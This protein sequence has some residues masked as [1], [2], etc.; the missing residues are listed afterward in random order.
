MGLVRVNYKENVLV[1]HIGIKKKVKQT[2]EFAYDVNMTRGKDISVDVEK[3]KLYRFV[4]AF[5]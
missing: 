1:L 3:R 5:P 2:N 4:P